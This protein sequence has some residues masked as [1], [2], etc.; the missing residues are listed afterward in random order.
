M[1]ANLTT[2]EE[3]DEAT[4]FHVPVMADNQTSENNI[5]KNIHYARW[6]GI[7]TMKSF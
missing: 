1:M 5:E 2:D 7:C 4:R 6:T 3:A